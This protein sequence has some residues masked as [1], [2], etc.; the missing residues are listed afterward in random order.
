MA[1][2]ASAMPILRIASC[3]A[4]SD[5]PAQAVPRIASAPSPGHTPGMK[6]RIGAP[7]R[8]H[9]LASVLIL[10][11]VLA[12]AA[13]SG[14]GPRS[15]PS[16]AVLEIANA[17]MD[18][19]VDYLSGIIGGLLSFDLGS[20]PSVALTDRR[21]LDAVLKEKELS[22]SAIGTDAAAAAEAGRLV[23]ADWLLT[24]E[25]VFTGTEVLLTLSLTDV[26][27]AKRAV[28]RGR[29]SDE[30][31]VHG[32]A[33]QVLLRLTGEA[34]ALA[35]PG[36]SRSLVSLRDETPGSI[37]LFSRIIRA[38]VFLDGEFF[39]YTTGD[40]TV[41][42]VF[43]KLSPGE[44]SLRVHLNSS[45]GV[46]DMPAVAFRD[47]EARVKVE[48]GKR[49]TARD[50]TRHFNE[51]LYELARVGEGNLK[52]SV[53]KDAAAALDPR[54]TFAKDFAFRDR[55]GAETAVRLEAKPRRADGA[56]YLDLTLTT[57]P[58]GGAAA[59]AKASLRLPAESEGNQ[60]V[61]AAA[62]LVELSADADR[63]AEYWSMDW[64][65]DRTDLRQNM[66]S[67]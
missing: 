58:K 51:V 65:L 59:T 38:E 45:F 23:G 54:M 40:G 30:N 67:E 11:S 14:P 37:A 31:L 41:P 43:D 63:Y 1:A 44:H 50:G 13:Q 28:F 35:E 57:T 34:S 24:G 48:P 32:L 22:L 55:S 27:T 52:P 62:G 53:P 7:A 29:G 8:A 49:A 64:R 3:V 5:R 56:V 16:V 46:V 9:A 19:R 15:V 26:E 21:N 20:R 17:G 6:H 25:Y 47:W 36:K 42:L 18:P 10:A 12:G 66:W 2:A 33:E 4:E 60:S 39:G 61:E